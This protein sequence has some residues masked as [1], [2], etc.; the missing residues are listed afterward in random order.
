MNPMESREEK[1]Q[2]LIAKFQHRC[3]EDSEVKCLI[4]EIERLNEIQKLWKE[5]NPTVYQMYETITELQAEVERLQREIRSHGPEGRNYTNQQYVDLRTEVSQLRE[6]LGFY[7]DQKNYS[8]KY[9]TN[10]NK[11]F[12][13]EMQVDR[14]TK[15]RAALGIGVDN[16]TR[17]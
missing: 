3:L 10:D 17:D 14:G 8:N 9:V 1:I 6:A 2:E 4:E 16:E 11:I 7:A 15:A 12:I 5:I 13:T